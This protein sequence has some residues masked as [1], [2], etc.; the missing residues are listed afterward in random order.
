METQLGRDWKEHSSM[1]ARHLLLLVL[2]RRKV[3]S[4]FYFIFLSG[5]SLSSLT[6]E[7]HYCPLQKCQCVCMFVFPDS[8]IS[9]KPMDRA[10]WD[11]QKVITGCFNPVLDGCHSHLIR[12]KFDV[13]AAES[14]PQ[15]IFW[16]IILHY[17]TSLL[18][19]LSR[20]DQNIV[21]SKHKMIKV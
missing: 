1:S 7:F 2:Q 16:Y 10:P 5:W 13:L 19:L 17:C 14:H 18:I 9:H 15:V 8:K 11:S 4:I 20:A 12:I 6:S 3:R 21:I